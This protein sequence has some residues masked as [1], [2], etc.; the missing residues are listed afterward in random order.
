MD[1]EH[2]TS[3]EENKKGDIVKFILTIQNEKIWI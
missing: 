2:E 3:E 1:K